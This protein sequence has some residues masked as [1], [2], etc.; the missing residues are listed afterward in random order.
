MVPEKR[1]DSLT[2]TVGLPDEVVVG[3]QSL[4]RV[5]QVGGAVGD[6]LPVDGV[7]TLADHDLHRAVDSPYGGDGVEMLGQSG[8]RCKH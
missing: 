8:R 5:S 7:V 2:D 6:R 4:D 3:R 1:T